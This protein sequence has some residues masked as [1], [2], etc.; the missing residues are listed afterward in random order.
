VIPIL[1]CPSDTAPNQI[2]YTGGSVVYYFGANTYGGNAGT[3]AF[4]YN[5]MSEDGIFY[6]NSRVRLTDIS[7]GSSNT[8]LFGERNR[9]DPAYG[10]IKGNTDLASTYS[11]WAWS[12]VYGGEDYLLGAT[13]N[14]RGLNWMITPGTTTDPGFVLG[15]DR[16]Q[17]YGS[18]HTGGANFC[19]A[20]GSVRFVSNSIPPAVLAA[21]CTRS[22]RE[23]VDTSSF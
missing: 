5:A 9:V 22:G 21:L 10:Q 1:I 15:D 8:F 18:Q 20:D 12:N 7:D 17:V 4:Y 11:G 6:H 14:G 2:T 3:S 23:V 16:V 13:Y 19:F